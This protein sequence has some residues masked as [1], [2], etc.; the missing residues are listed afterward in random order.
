M[1]LYTYKMMVLPKI[2]EYVVKQTEG[3]ITDFLWNG[4]KPKIPLRTLQ[5][6]KASGGQNLIDLRKKDIALKAMWV[7]NMYGRPSMC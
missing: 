1:S 4:R 6:N 5:L 3:L 7:E 2:P